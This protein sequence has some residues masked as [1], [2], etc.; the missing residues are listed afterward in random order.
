[1]DIQN[2]SPGGFASNCYLLSVGQDAVLIDCTVDVPTLRAAL[3]TRTLHAILLTHGHFDH[4]LSV[5]AVKAAFDVPILLHKGDAELPADGEKN[6]YAVFFGSDAA[7]PDADRLIQDGEHLT[8]GALD[9]EVLHTPGH[10][11]G[12]VCYRAAR[13]LFTGDTVFARG[14]GRTDL[15]GGQSSLLFRSLR[16]LCDLPQALR[17]YPGHGT[18][19]PLGA[20]L[21]QLF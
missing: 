5:S 17:I 8:F 14:F 15:Y 19:A 12:C 20:A 2:L 21:N 7:Y 6:A 4:M 9:L 13:A 11:Q 10:T 18:T 16:A 3:C 1:M